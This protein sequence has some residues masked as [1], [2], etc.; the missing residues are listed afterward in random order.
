MAARDMEM[1]ARV[2]GIASQLEKFD[3]LFGV[4]LGE[5]VLRLADN[6]SRTLQ[7]KQLSA[8]EGNHAAL[9]TCG[10]LSALR[11]DSEFTN[12]WDSVQTK[13]NDV[14]VGEAVLPRR[15]KTPRQLEVGTGE[16]HFPDSVQDY[17]RAQYFEALD[18]LTS[19]IKDRFDPP[20]YKVYSKLEALLLNSCYGVE[21]MAEFD[22]I[23][24]LY[25]QDFNQELLKSQLTILKTHFKDHSEPVR[26][27]VVH[28][29]LTNLGEARS[30]L[31]EMVKLLILVMP[32]T[33][34][35]SE[36]SFS[37]L[38]RV[39]TFLR[40]SM[41][42]SRLNHLMLLHVHK[43]ITDNL[44]LVDCANDFVSAN[45]HRQQVFGKFSSED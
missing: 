5:K 43:E 38:K 3:F 21:F 14:D 30:L 10:I 4:M 23:M 37:A 35:T 18:L 27:S 44:D 45:E 2:N 39:K 31:S 8:A 24:R 42:Q 17:Y 9:L 40:S 11:S 15:C 13:M 36:C 20:G 26:L 28:E 19:C 16:S 33:N 1:S 29:F 12:F 22:E 32:A 41:K 6:L 34:A 7:Q 25:A